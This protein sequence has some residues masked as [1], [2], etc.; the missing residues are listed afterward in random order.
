MR[1]KIG[2]LLVLTSII[3][4]LLSGIVYFSNNNE[5]EAKDNLA[6]VDI[7][8]KLELQKLEESLINTFGTDYE[9]IMVKN[10]NSTAIAENLEKSFDKNEFNQTV[11]PDNF[12]GMYINQ[13][14][15]LVVNIVNSDNSTQTTTLSL[16]YLNKSKSL[17]LDNSIIKNYVEYSYED[18]E[19]VNQTIIDYFITNGV[20]NSNFISNYI[21]TISNKVIVELK[22]I[23]VDEQQKFKNEV[24]DSEMIEFKQG[25]RVNL[26]ATYKAGAE[27]STSGSAY[28]SSGAYML[29]NKYCSIGFRAKYNGTNGYVTA[30]HCFGFMDYNINLSA[31]ASYG[32]FVKR[33]YNQSMDAAFISSSHTISNNLQ[34]PGYQASFINTTGSNYFTTGTAVGSAGYNGYKSGL[35][36]SLNYSTTDENGYYH[37]NLVKTNFSVVQ[38][39]SGGPVFTISTST[40]TSGCPL[41]GIVSVGDTSSMGFY[42]YNSVISSLGLTKY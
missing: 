3:S 22:D 17:Q 12:G 13:N 8:T 39:D 15:N 36:S 9:N 6:F 16:E 26:K 24:V 23:S 20:T 7:N 4:L 40:L 1:K 34:N 10:I 2:I 37:T 42:S 31:T 35:I 30:G 18:L 27:I 29:V 41:I 14:G 38:G 19:N 28:N 11:Y 32:T 21:D 33:V 5:I 25:E